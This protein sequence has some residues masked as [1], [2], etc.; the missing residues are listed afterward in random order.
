MLHRDMSV[1]RHGTK[2][3]DVEREEEMKSE[4]CWLYVSPIHLCVVRL[5]YDQHDMY[6]VLKYLML[7]TREGVVAVFVQ[8]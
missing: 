8:R 4:C 3:N 1:S 6:F 5:E 2:Q 7:M